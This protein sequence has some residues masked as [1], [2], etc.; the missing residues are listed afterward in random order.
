MNSS[1]G[2]PQSSIPIPY[3]SQYPGTAQ[4][5]YHQDSPS[6]VK[7]TCRKWPIILGS[8]VG[9]IIVLVVVI[10]LFGE[11]DSDFV[12]QAENLVSKLN[13][14]KTTVPTEYQKNEYKTLDRQFNEK[15][16]KVWMSGASKYWE[17]IK[18]AEESYFTAHQKSLDELLKLSE[19]WTSDEDALQTIKKIES[20][21]VIMP[22]NCLE[23]FAEVQKLDQQNRQAREANKGSS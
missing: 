6:P 3:S 18:T 1:S 2:N 22:R 15:Y 11:P 16:G 8:V 9:A 20:T 23:A 17:Q 5:Q 19:G 21:L 7:K 13:L 14:Y 4:P 10:C 12:T